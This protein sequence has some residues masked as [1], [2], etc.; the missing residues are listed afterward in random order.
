MYKSKLDTPALDMLFSA[1]LRLENKE[2]CYRFFEDLCT[3]NELQSLAQRL[4]VAKMLNENLTYHEI[5]RKTGASTATISRVNRCLEY[6][7]D[8][9]RIILERLQ[10][11]SKA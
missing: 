1:I 6:G 3:I 9:Y 10:N 8:G 11:Q 4:E 2:E 5:A 7:A